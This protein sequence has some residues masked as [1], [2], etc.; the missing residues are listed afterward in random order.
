MDSW[1]TSSDVWYFSSDTGETAGHWK[2]GNVQDASAIIN[3]DGVRSGHFTIR[4][5]DDGIVTRIDTK[6]FGVEFELVKRRDP[7]LEG[8]SHDSEASPSS[9]PSSSSSSSV[10]ALNDLTHLT[11]LNEPEMVE[12]L[13]RRYSGAAMYTSTGPI[14]LAVNPCQD[15][16]NYSSSLLDQYYQE[17]QGGGAALPPHIYKT[18]DCAYR[19]M[20]IDR[21]SPDQR[22]DQ[23]ILVNGESGAG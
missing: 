12:C 3:S 19:S 9:S 10:L 13:S 16:G 15:L 4:G 20:F 11:H 7:C 2:K 17:G 23:S 8:A 1:L 18:S 22:E 5:Q 21:F 6:E 14:L